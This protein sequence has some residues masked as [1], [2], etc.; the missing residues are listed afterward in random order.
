VQFDDA[1]IRSGETDSMPA[2]RSR[3][4]LRT[5]L[6]IVVLLATTACGGGAPATD[7]TEADAP[8]GDDGGGEEG[9][10]TV[11]L[12]VENGDL[13]GS[14]QAEGPKSDC[15]IGDTGSGATFLDMEVTNSLYTATFVSA[16]G[17]ASPGKFWFHAA[18]AGEESFTENPLQD[19]P[20]ISVDTGI[21][22]E[23]EGEGSAQLT[24]NGDTISWRIEGTTADGTDFTA[25]IECGPVDRR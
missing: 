5:A 9:R 12:N 11:D 4:A 24:D 7:D 22:G 17:G 8:A 13:A 21:A 19:S 16:E 3:A 25:T 10:V 18:F 2:T 14:Y 23:T 1:A 20:S 6:P 15:N